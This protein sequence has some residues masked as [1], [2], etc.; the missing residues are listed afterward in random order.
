MFRFQHFRSAP[1]STASVG[2][3]SSSPSNWHDALP[4]SSA[5]YQLHKHLRCYTRCSQRC[6]EAECQHS[7]LART[8]VRHIY[9]FGTCCLSYSCLWTDSTLATLLAALFGAHIINV[10][11]VLHAHHEWPTLV[12]PTLSACPRIGWARYEPAVS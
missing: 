10:A 6:A 8:A 2:M 9:H 12:L 5:I 7:S 1:D 4:P 11:P 3:L